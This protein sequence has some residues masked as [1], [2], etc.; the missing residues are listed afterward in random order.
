MGVR[1]AVVRRPPFDVDL[2]Q[3]LG[4]PAG[5]NRSSHGG[6]E[7]GE[8]QVVQIKSKQRPGAQFRGVTVDFCFLLPP[9]LPRRRI[10][11][12]FLLLLFRITN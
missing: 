5:S 6:N 12:E 8:R 10:S 7:V 3:S 11:A 1:N 9:A 4:A 2:A